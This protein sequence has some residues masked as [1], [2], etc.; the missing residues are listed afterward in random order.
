M[1]ARIQKIDDFQITEIS[2]VGKIYYAGNYIQ[3]LSDAQPFELKTLNYSGEIF[4]KSDVQT[5]FA[6]T[7][8]GT[9]FT[10]MPDSHIYY[11][12]KTKEFY[13]LKGLGVKKT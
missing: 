7:V 4:I 5:S 11:Q 9:Y 3:N 8:L 1:D 2:G 12:P 13:L 10:A 6:F